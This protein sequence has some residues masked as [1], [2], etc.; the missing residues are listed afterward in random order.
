MTEQ[1]MLQRMRKELIMLRG[2]VIVLTSLLI[3]FW[4]TGFTQRSDKQHFNEIDVERLNIVE[5]DGSFRF[6][7]TNGSRAP[8]AIIGG[9]EIR[10][11][12][13]NNSPAIIF[14]NEEGDENGALVTAGRKK[15]DGKFYAASRLVFDRFQRDE[16]L[17][18]QYYEDNGTQ[19]AGLSLQDT[20]DIPSS[21]FLE[22]NDS[23][24]AMPDG[25]AKKQALQK[26]QE[27]ANKVGAP[28]LFI[29]KG[30]NKAI[31]VNLRDQ[32]GQSR[33][34]LQVDSLGSP[35]MD[36]LDKNG[37]ITYSLPDS[38]HIAAKK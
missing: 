10:R 17:S 20:R 33:L 28:R 8:G 26:F 29:G 6:V 2:Y 34:R 22:G 37:N 1:Q 11:S 31:V 27:E 19:Y 23:I 16:M 3:V 9:K 21:E 12:N 35:R 5:A 36:F 7:L 15:P 32:L 38:A 30:R 14:Y 4:F 18:L 13:S 24:R 25:E